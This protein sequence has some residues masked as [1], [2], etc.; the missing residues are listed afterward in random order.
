VDEAA[1]L[2]APLR[3]YRHHQGV[4]DRDADPRTAV[5]RGRQALSFVDGPVKLSAITGQRRGWYRQRV[6][7]D[8]RVRQ[9]LSRASRGDH[10]RGEQRVHDD[11]LV[12]VPW[13]VMDGAVCVLEVHRKRL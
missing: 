5:R 11:Q 3:P 2:F 12:L 1:Q 7:V 6:A 10:G 4:T 9:V 8:A 13:V